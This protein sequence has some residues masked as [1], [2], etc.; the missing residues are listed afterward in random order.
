MP[1]RYLLR[2][3]YRS[4]ST[5]PLRGSRGQQPRGAA[6]SAAM[7]APCA[8]DVLR[9]AVVARK[10]VFMRFRRGGGM[11]ARVG[12]KLLHIAPTHPA[13]RRCG[14]LTLPHRRSAPHEKSAAET[15]NFQS[16]ADFFNA[17]AL[18]AEKKRR[19]PC[20]KNTKQLPNQKIFQPSKT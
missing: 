18:G 4:L 2:R 19:G 13:A 16:R 14:S 1:P 10:P 8:G 17:M 6:V 9:A 5:T 12:E 7:I 20:G 11:V 15:K 3:C